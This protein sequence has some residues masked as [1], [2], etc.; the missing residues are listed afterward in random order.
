MQSEMQQRHCPLLI[1]QQLK[2]WQ[3]KWE[4]AYWSM[5][6]WVI[7]TRSFLMLRLSLTCLGSLIKNTSRLPT[8]TSQLFQLKLFRGVSGLNAYPNSSWT[9]KD[10][11]M[12]YL[13]GEEMLRPSKEINCSIKFLHYSN[14]LEFLV[15]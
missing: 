11:W 10:S 12:M 2:H 14:P 3:P 8:W 7:L 15:P 1:K 5:L 13:N 4:R 6:L 9:R